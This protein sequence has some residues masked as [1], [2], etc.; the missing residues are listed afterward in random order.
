MAD[1]DSPWKEML[2]GYF[3]AFMAFFFPAAHADY[4]HRY[5]RQDILE[6][7]RFIDWIMVLPQ[8]LEA[9]FRTELARV[10]EETR[11]PYIT[12]I[13]R[14]GLERGRQEGLQQGLQQGEATVLRRLLTR[15][16]GPLPLWAEERLAQASLQE[17]ERWADRVLEAQQLDEIF[18]T[19]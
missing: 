10:E 16:F 15:R 9:R 8:E 12:S 4:E 13:E 1:Y 18:V 3:P 2:E 5:T 14:M 17:L 7:F 6:L 19:E 11:M